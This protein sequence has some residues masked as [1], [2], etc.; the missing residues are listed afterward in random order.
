M[1]ALIV[2]D[3]VVKIL[4]QFTVIYVIL[5]TMFLNYHSQD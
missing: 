4:P 3:C 2:Q 5:I 1:C